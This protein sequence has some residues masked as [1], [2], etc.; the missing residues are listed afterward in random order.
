M[1][2]LCLFAALA[3]AA[4]DAL[5][6]DQSGTLDRVQ[7]EHV[8]RVGMIA[9]SGA[10]CPDKS[11]AFLAEVS[12]AAGASPRTETGPAEPLLSALRRGDL[13]LVLGEVASDSPWATEVSIMEPL[14]TGCPGE[15]DYSAIGRNGENR[16]IM[17]LE[18]AGRTVSKG[19]A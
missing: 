15:V 13:D 6:K 10:H 14:A 7:A 17:L 12:R 4:C 18:D 1:K 16:W 9:G 2:G 5:P 8:F 11:R 19:G 3:L